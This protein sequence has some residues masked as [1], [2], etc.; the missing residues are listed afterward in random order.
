MPEEGDGGKE[1]CLKYNI[2]EEDILLP[3]FQIVALGVL[4]KFLQGQNQQFLPLHVLPHHPLPGYQK[5]KIFRKEE[6]G[7]YQ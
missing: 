5:F 3:H 1:T 6:L 2:W 4:D 7:E